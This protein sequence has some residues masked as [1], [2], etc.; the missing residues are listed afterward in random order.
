[1]ILASELLLYN[2]NAHT[3]KSFKRW[4]FSR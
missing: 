1:M 2:K 3:Y 4:P